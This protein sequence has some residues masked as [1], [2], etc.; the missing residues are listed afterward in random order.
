MSSVVGCSSNGLLSVPVV[1]HYEYGLAASGNVLVRAVR[2]TTADGAIYVPP[3]GYTVT[4][5]ACAR[6]GVVVTGGAVSGLVA[7]PVRSAIV[8][9]TGA[10]ASV[11]TASAPGLLQSVTVTAR[12]V[13][14]GY[15]PGSTANQIVV[16]CPDGSVLVM[17]NGQTFTWSVS[18]REQ[19]TELRREFTIDATGNAYANIGYTYV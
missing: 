8:A 3:A 18:G 12:G 16:T 4:A 1:I 13:T 9:F 19:E 5:G 7:G 11:S 15:K 2:Y 17:I 6:P 10:P 14:D